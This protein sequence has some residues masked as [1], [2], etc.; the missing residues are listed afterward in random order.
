MN[1]LIYRNVMTLC[2]SLSNLIMIWCILTLDCWWYKTNW[3]L[4]LC[5]FFYFWLFPG[6]RGRFRGARVQSERSLHRLRLHQNTKVLQVTAETDTPQIHTWK[7]FTYISFF[8]LVVSS[9]SG[10]IRHY[11]IKISDTGQ[12]FLAEKHTFNSIPD[13]IHYHE[14]NAAGTW[15]YTV[16][17]R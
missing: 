5:F 2:C 17:A 16:R 8:L 11:Q 13:V 6:Q 4:F 3:K 12:F 14:H 15:V 10:D 7:I 9:A 1:L